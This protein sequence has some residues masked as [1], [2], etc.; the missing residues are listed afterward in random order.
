M[1]L[2]DRPSTVIAIAV[3]L[4]AIVAIVL[5]AIFLYRG[6]ERVAQ[7]SLQRKYMGLAVHEFP[8][9]GDV[10][11]S[12]YTYHGLVA[13]LTHTSHRVALPPDD[14]RRLLGRLLRFNLT[15][16]LFTHGA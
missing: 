11:V 15:W 10:I 6:Y 13:W 8:Q 7:R 2:A 3:G 16:G 5:F 14:A 9:P 12:Y 1:L 4:A